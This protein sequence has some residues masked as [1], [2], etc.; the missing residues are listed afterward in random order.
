MLA[1]AMRRGGVDSL[2]REPNVHSSKSLKI[3]RCKT[4]NRF[5]MGLWLHALSSLG[6]AMDIS[7]FHHHF[8][9]HRVLSRT[10][11]CNRW[12]G[13]RNTE[14]TGRCASRQRVTTA[15]RRL[16]PPHITGFALPARENVA[17]VPFVAPRAGL[18]K[19]ATRREIQIQRRGV[20]TVQRPGMR[21]KGGQRTGVGRW[22][23]PWKVRGRGKV[24]WEVMAGI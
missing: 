15:T 16:S 13:E 11:T 4:P 21:G 20:G 22:R 18:E 8:Y 12:N 10:P 2:T 6:F 19:Q 7:L 23:V 1:C 24:P 9:C 3:S 14:S 17:Y 5:G